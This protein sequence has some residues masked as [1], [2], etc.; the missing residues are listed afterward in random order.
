MCHPSATARRR[1]MVHAVRRAQRLRDECAMSVGTT[2][3]V[4]ATSSRRTPRLLAAR[5]TRA[6]PTQSAH[7]RGR[8]PGR[9]APPA[10][11]SGHARPRA[12]RATA[13]AGS[14]AAVV[15]HDG[16]PR[17]DRAQHRRRAAAGQNAPTR[18]VSRASTGRRVRPYH[19][20]PWRTTAS[21][22]ASAAGSPSRAPSARQC[23]DGDSC[24][25]N[26]TTIVP[27]PSSTSDARACTFTRTK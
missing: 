7:D 16:R 14:T 6:R 5:P 21:A 1:V 10:H 15:T 22:R 12:C 17:A 2:R 26:C 24:E 23:S 19:R 11:G 13:R 27:T 25:M 4:R 3:W 8:R 9:V 20:H 18:A